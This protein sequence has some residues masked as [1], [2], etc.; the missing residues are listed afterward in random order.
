VGTGLY[1]EKG[2]MRTIKIIRKRE[3]IKKNKRK[4]DYINK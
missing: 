4:E 1:N 2:R 3:L